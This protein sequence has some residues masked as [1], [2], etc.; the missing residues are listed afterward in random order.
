VP[1]SPP[2]KHK[3]TTGCS[4]GPQD[5]RGPPKTVVHIESMAGIW[6]FRLNFVKNVCLNYYSRNLVW[7]NFRGDNARVFQRVS[8]RVNLN[9]TVGQAAC[10]LLCRYAHSTLAAS[11][12]CWI[13]PD[14]DVWLYQKNLWVFMFE[15]HLISGITDEPPPLPLAKLNVK[16]GP[17]R[18][19]YFG[20][21]YSFFFNRLLFFCVFR[22]IFRWFRVFV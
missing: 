9:M 19:L 10:Q 3:H 2:I 5:P 13:V 17:L 7:F 20:I 1:R 16:T 15:M 14:C 18:S 8:I 22:S 4:L 21:Y 11:C 12:V 6:S